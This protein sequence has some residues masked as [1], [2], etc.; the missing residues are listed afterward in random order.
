MELTYLQITAVASDSVLARVVTLLGAR[1]ARIVELRCS[2]TA[3]NTTRISCLVETASGRG[4]R[5][6]AVIGRV[7]DVIGVEIGSA[8]LSAP[9]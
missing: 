7:V 3:A 1:G 2:T 8:R 5:V 9:A 4:A 6:A